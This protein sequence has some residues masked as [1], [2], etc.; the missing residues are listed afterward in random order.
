M[1]PDRRVVRVDAVLLALLL[2]PGCAAGAAGT[3]RTPDPVSAR[4]AT[5]AVRSAAGAGRSTALPTELVG[6]WSGTDP[7][8]VGSWT[9]AFDADGSY[10]EAN[11]RRGVS[12]EGRAAV[13]GRRLFLQPL[14]ADSRT[15]TW[16]V[17]GGRL[18]LD[19][20]ATTY[21]RL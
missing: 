15:V 14:D 17:S 12:V 13:V 10:R 20:A 16:E 21:S 18:R 3:A 5:S 9:I 19:G 8:G 11:P 4:P 1:R 2:V 6:S 7:Q